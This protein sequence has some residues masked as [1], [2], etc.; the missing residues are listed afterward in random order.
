MINFSDVEKRSIYVFAAYCSVF[1]AMFYLVFGIL[2][3]LDPAEAHRGAEFYE[4]MRAHP[5]I[6]MTWRIFFV[7]IG[8]LT[9]PCITGL[10]ML[11]RE[12]IQKWAGL[13]L[14][15]LILGYGGAILTSIE[16]MRE[17]F[18]IK[19]M[20]S[21]FPQADPMYDKAIEVASL[22]ADPDFLWKFGG[23]GLWYGLI[24]YFGLK[25][26]QLSK[27]ASIFGI[28]SFVCLITAMIFGMTDTLLKFENGVELAVMQIP[29]AIG[30]AIGA[31]VFHIWA[32]RDL[33]KR[34]KLIPKEMKVVTSAAA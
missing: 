12:K 29:A 26:K 11:V 27:T 15:V 14:F 23:L 16:W 9:I 2:V 13:F 21:F 4:N 7:I 28:L 10:S 6:P 32:A 22:P 3:P 20:V 1:I 31:P 24:S 17:Y 34:A 18:T 30:G 8:F 5:T 33:F 19:M 25:T